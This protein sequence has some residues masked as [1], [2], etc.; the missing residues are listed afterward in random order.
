MATSSIPAARQLSRLDRA[1][2]IAFSQAGWSAAA[3]AQ[4]LGCH[5][6]TVYRWRRRYRT[7]GA[8]GLAPRSHRPHTPHPRTTPAALVAQLA[9]IRDAHPGWGARLIRRQLIL[10]GCG[11]LP[12]ERTIATWLTKLGYGP[13]RPRRSTRLG[14]RP[15]GAAPAASWQLDFKQKGG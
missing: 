4:H 9:A 13:V 2:I 3:I 15:A 10:D 1:R 7:A 8:A 5:P 14:W 12:T 11:H 6:R